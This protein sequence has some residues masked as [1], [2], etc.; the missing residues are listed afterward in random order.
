MT[1]SRAMTLPK[2]GIMQGRLSPPVGGRIQAFPAA[3]WHA[4]FEL[5]AKLGLASI[6]WIVESPLPSN[7]LMTAAGAADVRTV[8]QRTGVAVDFVI[9][10]YFMESPFVRMSASTAEHNRTVLATLLEHAAKLGA[11]GVEIPCVDASEIRTRA[12]EDEL[13]S[14]LA[15]ALAQAERL[16]VE[17]GLETSLPPERFRALLER[18]G[19]PRIRANYDTGN[20]A[21]LGYDPAEE[22]AAYGPWI[23]NVHIKDRRHGGGTVPLGQGDTNI[24]R[25]LKLLSGI[26]Y[27][28]DYIL[29]AARGPDEIETVRSYLLQVRG[30]LGAI[31]AQR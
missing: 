4:E 27:R 3:T 19:H 14:A 31:A 13:A 29:Q 2:I 25:V 9:A 23:N 18:I 6:E 12:E 24:P 30:W 28:G 20:S 8:V 26:P 17:L 15:P 16:G 1:A 21:S 22:F 10:D 7:P 11:R 5:A